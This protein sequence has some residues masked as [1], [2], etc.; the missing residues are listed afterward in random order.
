MHRF[1]SALRELTENLQGIFIDGVRS[2]VSH[3]YVLDPSALPVMPISHAQRTFGWHA[4]ALLC[5]APDGPPLLFGEYSA[6][7]CAAFQEP[8]N[9]GAANR[10]F[11]AGDLKVEGDVPSL[12]NMMKTRIVTGV[13]LSVV[14]RVHGRGAAKVRGGRFGHGRREIRL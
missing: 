9:A 3:V 10:I 1:L 14:A 7:F 5:A 13:N 2:N 4:E 8:K 12:G 6:R 11:V